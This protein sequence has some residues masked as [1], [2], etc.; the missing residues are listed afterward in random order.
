MRTKQTN[1]I[2]SFLLAF[3]M[4][5]GMVPASVFAAD[6]NP[7]S[8]EDKSLVTIAESGADS[9]FHVV[10]PQ[11]T[12]SAVYDEN[13]H[14][15]GNYVGRYTFD[16]DASFSGTSYCLDHTKSS[17]VSQPGMKTKLI[18]RPKDN[19]DYVVAGD[20]GKQYI[21]GDWTAGV[22]ASG[23]NS[24]RDDY[25]TTKDFWEWTYT[26]YLTCKDLT[27]QDFVLP[28]NSHVNSDGSREDYV[29]KMVN[30]MQGYTKSQF[31]RATQLAVWHSIWNLNIVGAIDSSLMG[32]DVT[33]LVETNNKNDNAYRVIAVA[34]ALLLHG[35]KWPEPNIKYAK[36]GMFFGGHTDSDSDFLHH[37]ETITTDIYG[38][39]TFGQEQDVLYDYS[40]SGNKNLLNANGIHTYE[41]QKIDKEG[42]LETDV[43]TTGTINDLYSASLR[44][45]ITNANNNVFKQKI[46]G[47]DY[48]VIY[49][50]FYTETD[51]Q[52]T[53]VTLTTDWTAG[54]NAAEIKDKGIFVT[55]IKPD[56]ASKPFQ[57]AEFRHM[58]D[59]QP[60]TLEELSRKYEETLDASQI[61]Y[62]GNPLQV[63]LLKVDYDNQYGIDIGNG[64]RLPEGNGYRFY[65]MAK[66]CVPIW[67]Y[68]TQEALANLRDL[69]VKPELTPEEAANFPWT[70]PEFDAT[71]TFSAPVVSQY[72][73]YISV[74]EGN[75]GTGFSDGKLQPML[76]CDGPAAVTD[77]LRIKWD[78]VHID[79]DPWEPPPPTGGERTLTIK[80]VDGKDNNIAIQGAVFRLSC[81]DK[82]CEHYGNPLT[83]TTNSS[84]IATFTITDCCDHFD[85]DESPRHYPWRTVGTPP[86]TSLVHGECDPSQIGRASC[87]ERV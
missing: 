4:V 43:A 1:R 16:N 28:G 53:A 66:L 33:K 41:Y 49:F 48:Y 55:A 40:P 47:Q 79:R 20:D 22:V 39:D 75:E 12:T 6:D 58:M 24:K 67:V 18:P 9:Y 37:V 21:I 36:G 63:K 61:N 11:D 38:A 76:L 80:K 7:A 31:D 81:L 15:L 78:G 26:K 82:T 23:S 35:Y 3:V 57:H 27:G 77:T 56:D 25:P 17:I 52:D 44:P 68:N 72:S 50:N 29:T 73:Q 71:F 2:I 5:M 54:A 10:T 69:L 84:G 74:P 59:G 45:G 83:E 87:R 60:I 46:N 30:W 51:I 14:Q 32:T 19:S 85:Y 70:A 34:Q 8:A 62:G 13:G 42:N 86:N 64:A 65:G